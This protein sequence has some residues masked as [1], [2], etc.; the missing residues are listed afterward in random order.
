MWKPPITISM[1]SSA[2]KH[3]PTPSKKK[4]SAG[5]FVFQ[6]FYLFDFITVSSCPKSD[7]PKKDT[8]STLPGLGRSIRFTCLTHDVLIDLATCPLLSRGDMGKRHQGIVYA[9]HKRCA[10]VIGDS[11]Q[12]VTEKELVLFPVCFSFFFLPASR[13]RC[14]ALCCRPCQNCHAFASS[15]GLFS[16]RKTSITIDCCHMRARIQRVKNY[17]EHSKEIETNLT[18]PRRTLTVWFLIGLSGSGMYSR[19]MP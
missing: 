13:I 10:S 8:N 3:A 1:S 15:S 12:S 7:T 2:T 11:M 6:A 17:A 5:C 16:S 19:V 14:L 9:R 18:Q 4:W